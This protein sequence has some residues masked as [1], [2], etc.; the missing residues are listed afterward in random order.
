MQTTIQLLS[1]QIPQGTPNP[2]EN[3]A[4]DISR[5]FDIIVYII[6]PILIVIFYL[7]WRQKKRK[8]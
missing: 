7:V 6:L 2:G 1:A 5:P 8:K 3:T 4:I